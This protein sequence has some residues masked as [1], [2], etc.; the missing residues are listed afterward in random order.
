VRQPADRP[1]FSLSVELPP[2]APDCRLMAEVLADE[3]AGLRPDDFRTVRSYPLS[4]DRGD[5]PFV[6]DLVRVA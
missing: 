6:L 1:G 3:P 4:A 5:E 2:G